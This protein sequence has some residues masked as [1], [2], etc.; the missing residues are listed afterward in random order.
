MYACCTGFL[1]QARNQFFDFFACCHHQVG[2][3]VYHHH[4]KWQFFQ[5]IR[6]IRCDAEWVNNGL[7]TRFGIGNFLVITRQIAHTHVAHQAIALLHFVY[8]PIERIGRQL[9]V[10]HNGREQMWN[11]FVYR[12]LQH[13]RIDHDHAHFF[14]RGLEEHGQN[15][16]VHTHGFA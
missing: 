11:A 9:H 1:G 2:K 5:Q 16:R 4:D 13:F 12:Q 7:A 10:G 14:R 3:F 15:H 6:L 8:T